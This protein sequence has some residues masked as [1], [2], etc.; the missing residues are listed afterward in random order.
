MFQSKASKGQNDTPS[1]LFFIAAWMQVSG[2]SPK[3]LL[4]THAQQ[5]TH[6]RQGCPLAATCLRQVGVSPL[7]VDTRS[8]GPLGRLQQK[9]VQATQ[10]C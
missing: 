5:H 6:Y 7:Q 2:N 9:G 3:A 8:H 10:L 1:L 4:Q